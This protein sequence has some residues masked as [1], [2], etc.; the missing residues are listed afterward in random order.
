MTKKSY[1]VAA[2]ALYTGTISS[3]ALAQQG[4]DEFESLIVPALAID[5]GIALAR[6][7][8]AD[9]DLLGSAGTLERVLFAHPEAAAPRLLY[10]S[11]MC[12][13]D[14]PDGA[15]LEISLLRGRAVP[16]DAWAEVAAACGP[17]DRPLPASGNDGAPERN[18]P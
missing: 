9:K 4:Q 15:R 18:R 13:L 6:R 7:Q 1:L 3:P 8:I 14:D 12:R 10:A 5:S 17:L 2:I 11:V 16:D